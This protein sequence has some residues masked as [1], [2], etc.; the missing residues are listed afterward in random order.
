LL[1]IVIA[2][3][4]LLQ[5]SMG[6]AQQPPNPLPAATAE[7]IDRRALVSR[8]NVNFQQIDP[9][10]PAMVGNGN[11]AFTADITGLQTF[12]EQYSP[13][14]PLLTQSQWGWHSFPNPAHF[15]YEDSLVP[16]DVRGDTQ[17]YPWLRDWSEAKKPAIAWL[18]ENPHR[19]SLGRVSLHLISKRG[20]PAR[21]ADLSATQQTLD[22]WSGALLSSFELDGEPVQ[23][24]TRVHPDLDMLIVTLT[25]PALAA[26]RLG[27]DLKFPGVASALN[28]DPAD[29]GHPERHRT[30]VTARDARRLSLERKLDDTH[31]YV[32]VGADQD[33]TFT[34]GSPHVFRILPNGAPH[35][36]FTIPDGSKRRGPAS[37]PG[38]RAVLQ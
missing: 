11:L 34:L 20:K 16:V 21:F 13:L 5:P 33:V 3:A 37:A 30:I 29:W 28:P 1:V 19:I 22:L 4:A 18:R 9:T 23:V 15:K 14:V 8:H 38:G 6:S 36:A 35:R 12:A 31:Y 2:L 24:Q 27:V 26:G 25:G 10:S 7:K 32:K 17:Y